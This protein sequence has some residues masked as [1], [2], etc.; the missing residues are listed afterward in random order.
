MRVGLG[1][2]V[3][4]STE[5]SERMFLV[6]GRTQTGLV[7]DEDFALGR[8]YP[9]LTAIR[10]VSVKIATAGACQCS[11]SVPSVTPSFSRACTWSSRS[12]ASNL[13]LSSP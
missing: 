4:E 8:I 11:A 12:K 9:S 6:A 2:L 3:V 5:V 10:E 1:A 13:P 7:T